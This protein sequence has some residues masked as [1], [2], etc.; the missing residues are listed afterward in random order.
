LN[1][2]I[3]SYNDYA[4]FRVQLAHAFNGVFTGVGKTLARKIPQ[5][6]KH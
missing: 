3:R 6:Q 2:Q 4:N 5:E 1:Q